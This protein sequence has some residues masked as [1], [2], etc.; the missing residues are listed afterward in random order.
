MENILVPFP[1]KPTVKVDMEND[2]FVNNK[3]SYWIPILR[4]GTS[5]LLNKYHRIEVFA[6]IP[7]KTY[8][9]ND[10]FLY[11][12]HNAYTQSHQKF[13]TKVS[14][15]HSSLQALISYKFVY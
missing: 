15:T 8:E 4:F 12:F 2:C 13:D 9:K 3:A 6:K 1:N 5:F 14:Y 7:L 10:D 11:E